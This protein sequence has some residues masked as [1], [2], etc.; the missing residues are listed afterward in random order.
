MKVV[1]DRRDRVVVQLQPH[2]AAVTNRD[3]RDA[4]R[5][6]QGDADHTARDIDLDDAVRWRQEAF[7]LRRAAV[8]LDVSNVDASDIE[9]RVPSRSMNLETPRVARIELDLAEPDT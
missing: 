4:G 6:M 9:H 2:R 8:H 5:P 1:D 3:R 7:D